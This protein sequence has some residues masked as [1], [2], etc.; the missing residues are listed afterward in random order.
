MPACIAETVFL[1]IAIPG[2]VNS[3]LGN[4]DASWNNAS[5]DI[6]I[7]GQI[8]PPRYSPLSDIAQNVV[9]VP[10]STMINGYPYFSIAATAFTIL[11]APT[12]LGLSYFIFNP[13]FIPGPTIN[14]STPQ[15]F[16]QKFSREC[17]TSGTTDD[18]I[19]CF[20]SLIFIL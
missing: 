5:L 3:T 10:K 7:P 15:Y 18:I 12:C 9:A 16:M 14:G 8:E 19:I 17:I 4:L 1:Q 20:T 2:F 6:L 13:V 11:S